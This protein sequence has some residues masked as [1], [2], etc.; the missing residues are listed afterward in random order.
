MARMVTPGTDIWPGDTAGYRFFDRTIPSHCFGG[1]CRLDSGT[2]GVQA[3]LGLLTRCGEDAAHRLSVR[4]VRAQDPHSVGQR[5]LIQRDS[6]GQVTCQLVGAGVGL[7]QKPCIS[8]APRLSVWAS[9]RD[10]SERL[11]Q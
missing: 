4:V 1:L 2:V 5:L 7:S 3:L 8:G 11:I 10:G 9:H 6:A